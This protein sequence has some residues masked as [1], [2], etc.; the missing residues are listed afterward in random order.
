MTK[1]FRSELMKLRR[2]R[3]LYG[4]LG[5]LIG[6][7]VLVTVLTFA[8]ATPAPS[9]LTAGFT[10]ASRL[11][12]LVVL[13]VFLTGVTTEYGLGTLRTLLLRQP[14]RD[15]LLAGK[16]LALAACTAGALLLALAVSVACAA[17]V[18]GVRGT[19]SGP[20][21]ADAATGYANTVLA[22][23]CY[24]AIGLALG[25]L[26][27]STAVAVGVALCWFIMVEN[28]ARNTWPGAGHLMPGLLAGAVTGVPGSV[29]YNHGLAGT[30]VYG[31]LALTTAF[32]VFTRRDVRA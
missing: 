19:P 32:V 4:G 31:A 27:R 23:A 7:T 22:A 18:T 29:P 13:V 11:V 25:V 16:V 14:L 12:G 3:V 17:V 20:W 24:G 30:L 10:N 5:A 26:L 6:C 21:L 8:T 28:I 15:R 1:A 2:P 9:R